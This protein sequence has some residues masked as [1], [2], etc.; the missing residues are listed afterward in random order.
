MTHRK[1]LFQGCEKDSFYFNNVDNIRVE[2][3]TSKDGQD[4]KEN[5]PGA[6]GE[7]VI[8][9]EEIAI[10]DAHYTTKTMTFHLSNFY[11]NKENIADNLIWTVE[12][13]FVSDD[14]VQDGG[15][16]KVAD[17]EW[18]HFRLNKRVGSAEKFTTGIETDLC[19][20]CFA[21]CAYTQKYLIK[22][23]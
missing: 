18:A 19:G 12:T 16:P 20:K 14:I 1:F 10:C 4:F 13:P 9:K 21:V 3:E 23:K 7:V 17:Y 22:N 15:V 5:Q 2:V 6:I 8:A 11:N